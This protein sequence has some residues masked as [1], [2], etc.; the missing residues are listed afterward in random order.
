VHGVIFSLESLRWSQPATWRRFGIASQQDADTVA[1]MAYNQG[2]YN[3]FLGVG[4]LV[5]VVLLAFPGVR[6]AGVG[7]AV[8][9]VGSML[10]AAT[11]LVLSNRALA[12]AALTQGLFPLVAVLAF[13]GAGL[14][15]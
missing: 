2:F 9:A 14:T 8:L 11:V 1:P 7:V 13:L 5:G 6:Q 10:A 15:A 3:L 4:A 12:R